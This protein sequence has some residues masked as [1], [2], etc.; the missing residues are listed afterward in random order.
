MSDI[1]FVQN[2]KDVNLHLFSLTSDS[3][4]FDINIVKVK[5]ELQENCESDSSVF[6]L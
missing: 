1:L 4:E 5:L 6:V 3:I 2:K